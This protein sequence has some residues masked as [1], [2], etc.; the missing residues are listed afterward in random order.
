MKCLVPCGTTIRITAPSTQ[1]GRLA[2]QQLASGFTAILVALQ[3]DLEYFSKHLK[4]PRWNTNKNC[5]CLCQAG[6]IGPNTFKNFSPNAPWR[7]TLWSAAAWR[8]W[9]GRSQCVLFSLPHLNC[10]SVCLDWVHSKYLGNDQQQ[11]ASVLYLLCFELMGGEAAENLAHLWVQTKEVYT[12][13]GITDRYK[14]LGKISM[15]LKPSGEVKL[16]GKAVEVKSLGPVLLVLW[17]RYMNSSLEIHRMVRCLLQ[18]NC[19]VERVLKEHKC[20][21]ALP[22]AAAQR[23][24]QACQ[25]MAHVQ[26]LLYDHFT[27]EDVPKLFSITAKLHSI[28]HISSLAHCISPQRV[29]CFAGEDY[30]NVCKVLRKQCV[31]GTDPHLAPSKMMEHFRLGMH[32]QLQA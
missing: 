22:P 32:Y 19:E 24:Y 2:G 31:H 18:L 17:A 30:M 25:Q 20:A 12:A 10:W 5:C 11:F 1:A 26:C 15:F 16:R 7:Q 14:F 13:L 8:L 3:G 27:T 6:G 21:D 28:V 9:A 29:W 4:L 23:F